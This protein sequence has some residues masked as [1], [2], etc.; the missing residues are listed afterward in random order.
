MSL[1]TVTLSGMSNLQQGKEN[2]ATYEQ[3][4]PLNEQ[5]T[6]L[7]LSIADGMIR[8][9][10]VPCTACHYCVSHCPK[11]LPIPDLLKLYNEAMVAGSGMFIAPMALSPLMLAFSRLM[12]LS[13]AALKVISS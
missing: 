12:S 1:A 3:A 10:T 2:I 5:E 13:R 7:V 8:R 6:A 11:H 9:T 4:R